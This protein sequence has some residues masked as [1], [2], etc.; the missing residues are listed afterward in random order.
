MTYIS[1]SWPRAIAHVDGDAFFASVE[2]AVKPYLKGRPVVTGK[3]RNIVAAASYEARAF[4][5]KR[6]VALWEAK[7]MCPGLVV[8]PTDYETVSIFSQRMYEIM[9]RYS[10]VVEE[11]SVDEAFVDL[12]GVRRVHRMKYEAIV[13]QIQQEIH[14]EL[15]I[16]VSVGLSVSKVL[17]K[18][19]SKWQKPAGFTRI[20]MYEREDRLRDYPLDNIWNIGPNTAGL[21]QG[22]G[23]RTALAFAN[24]P[25]GLVED[26]LTKPGVEVWQELNGESVWP[27]E[28]GLKQKVKSISKTKTFTPPSGDKEY[29]YAQLIKNMENACIK[30]RRYKR[31][32]K[33]VAVFLKEQNYRS[34]GMET[35]LAR[36]TAWPVELMEVIRKMFDQLYVPGQQYR[37]TG[38]IFG[39]LNSSETVQMSLFERR[40]NVEKMRRLYMAV[41]ELKEKYGKHAVHQCVSLPAQSVQHLTSRGDMPSRK[42][43]LITGET[44]RRRLPLPMLE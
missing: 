8:L 27:V 37:A 1:N 11:Y 41:D 43:K 21:L 42:L 29:V 22:H 35:K 10:P 3:E 6:G 44:S 14:R 38:C 17:A 31:A 39:E 4:G 9:R 16:T 13:R 34:L 15:N 36:P 26:I 28:T 23:I 24:Q 19:A 18:I 2:Q 7:K 33:T 5:V 20:S 32:P 40:G 30:A 25:R 12:T